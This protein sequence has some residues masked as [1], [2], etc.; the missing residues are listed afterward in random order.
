[1]QQLPD[2]WFGVVQHSVLSQWACRPLRSTGLMLNCTELQATAAAAAG[3]SG[4]RPSHKQHH[5][6]GFSLLS[7]DSRPLKPHSRMFKHAHFSPHPNIT[8]S[9]DTIVCAVNLLLLSMPPPM[10]G[11]VM[12]RRP[13]PLKPGGFALSGV[14]GGVLAPRGLSPAPA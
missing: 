11:S 7:Y 6:W 3:T 2:Q 13:W 5:C 10:L 9:S 1:M 14:L 12:L 4:R 8:S